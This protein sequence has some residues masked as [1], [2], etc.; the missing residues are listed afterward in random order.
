MIHNMTTKVLV[1]IAAI[2]TLLLSISCESEHTVYDGPNYIMFSDSLYV[3]PVQNSEEYFDIP[4]SATNSVGYDRVIAVEII[5]KN[6]NAIE[7]KHYQLESN[8]LKIK[9]GELSTNVRVLGKYE[10]ISVTDSLGF[11]LHLITNEETHWDLYGTDANVVLRKTCPF[12]IEDFTGYCTISSSYFEA[13]M[14]GVT[15][16]LIKSRINPDNP[17][18]IILENY[19]YDGYDIEVEFDLKD[20][21]HPLLITKEQPFALT[22]EAFGTLYGDGEVYMF[23]PPLYTSYYSTCKQFLVQY[24][25]LHVPNVGTVGT[26]LNIVKW[27]SD[28]EAELLKNAR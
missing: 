3:L 8:T 12:N 7:G 15:T 16:R 21:L 18:G 25:T 9:A 11:A 4:V 24:M 23:Q 2:M 26:Y 19:F 5:D 10:N 20:P 28:D 22:S 27:I 13:Y 6:S 1:G 14:P 17:N